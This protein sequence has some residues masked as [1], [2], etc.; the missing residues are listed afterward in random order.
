MLVNP[1]NKLNSNRSVNKFIS[2]AMWIYVVKRRVHVS[3]LDKLTFSTDLGCY[4]DKLKKN[5][6]NFISVKN[7]FK[8]EDDF[9]INFLKHF[10]SAKI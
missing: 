8:K 6:A 9:K 1:Y 10:I 3:S 2:A 5:P 4:K 7:A